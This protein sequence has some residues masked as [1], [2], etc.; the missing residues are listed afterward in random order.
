MRTEKFDVAA[1]P[2]VSPDWAWG[3]ADGSGVRVAVLD[4]GVDGG[5]PLIPGLERSVQVVTGPDGAAQVADCEPGDVAGHGT[6]CAGLISSIAP[7]VAISA[8]RRK[9]ARSA[10]SCS[11][12]QNAGLAVDR[13]ML[14]RS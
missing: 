12:R 2:Q 3:G 14:I 5:H 9:Y 11:A 8:Q 4:S 7:A 13:L 1:M 10:S 6:A